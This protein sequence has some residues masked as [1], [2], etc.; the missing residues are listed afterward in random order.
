[1]RWDLNFELVR[2]FD[3]N[4][5]DPFQLELFYYTA[6]ANRVVYWLLQCNR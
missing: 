1:M 5:L 2:P 4:I 6:I 3:A